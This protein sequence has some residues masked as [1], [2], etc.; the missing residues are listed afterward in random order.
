MAKNIKEN[1]HISERMN[2]PVVIMADLIADELQCGY[3]DFKSTAVA[4]TWGHDIDVP[5]MMLYFTLL[6]SLSSFVGDD[7]SLQAASMFKPGAVISGCKKKLFYNQVKT[8]FF[9]G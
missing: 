4:D 3:I 5:E 7:D 9:F 8:F 1:L 2:V 6:L